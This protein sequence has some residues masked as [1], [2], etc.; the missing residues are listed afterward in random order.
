MAGCHKETTQPVYETDQAL[1]AKATSLN[2]FTYYK[3][4]DS[5]YRSSPQSAHVAY[6]RVRFNAIAQ[7]ALNDS[8]KL[9]VGT[10]FPVGSIIVK[11]LHP[12]SLGLTPAGYAIMEKQPSDT[13]QNES[14]LWA[15][16]NHT[17]SGNTI[18]N[19]G[20]ICTS[21]HSIND[22]DKIRLFNLFP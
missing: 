20:A 17:G 16:Y 19:K 13:N 2:G 12:D 6:F 3:N 22:R 15:E 18:N 4:S 10:H 9:P 14:W 11:E 5:I 1:F 8:G 21:C 7:S